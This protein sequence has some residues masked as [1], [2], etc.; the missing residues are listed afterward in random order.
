MSTQMKPLGGEEIRKA[1]LSFFEERG[2]RI[3]RS[4][5]LV[6]A[7]DPTLLFTNAGMVPFKDVFT[8]REK[9]DYVRAATVQKCVRAGGKHNDLENVGFTARHHTFFEMLGNFSFG[10]YFKEE[11]IAFAWEFLTGVL[12]MPKERLAVTVFAGEDGI[13]A[14]EEAEAIWRRVSGLPPE[15][16]QRMGAADNFWMM[17]DVGPCGPSSE[18][19]WHQGED[20]PCEEEA[21]GRKCLGI[22]CEC[23]R[24]L[25]IWNLVFM[26]FDRD[27]SGKLTPLPRPSIDTGAGLE[28]IAAVLQGKPSNYETDIFRAIIDPIGE[29]AG[30]PYESSSEELRTSMRVIADHARATS[31]LVADGVLPS[32]EGRGYVLRR[33]MRRAIRHGTRLGF[34]EPFLH[35]ICKLVVGQM[36]AAYPELAENETLILEVAR[37]EEEGFRRTLSR[38]LSLIQTEIDSRRGGEPILPGDVVFRL[39]DTYGFPVDLTR[40]IAK[41]Q[42]FLIDEDG[43]RAHLEEQRKRSVF[44]GSGEAAV[45]DL[46]LELANT[47]GK[48][49]F[50]GYEGEGVEGEGKVV[51]LIRDGALVEEA[52][53]GEAVEVVLDRT[54]FY[55]E[56]GG[57]VGDAGILTGSRSGTRSTRA[58]LEVQIRDTQLPVPGLIVHRGRVVSGILR[59]GERVEAKV[60]AERRQ[61]IRLNHSAT[62]L[63]HRAL[64]EELGSHV[65]QAGSV[66]A[67]DYLR[68]DY[69]HFQGLDPETLQKIETRVNR[70]IRDDAD[71]VTREMSLDE[72]KASG[73]Q[74]LFGE[75]YEERVRVVQV[76]PR[77]LE[78]CGGT[79]VRRSGEIGLFK[80]VSEGSIAA[81]VRRIVAVTG[82]EAIRWLHQREKETLEVARLLR[83]SPGELGSKVEAMLRRV[84]ELEKEVES[85]QG[86]IAQA[87]TGDLVAHAREVGGV[88]V[89]ST[90]APEEVADLREFADRMRNKLGSGV[91]ALGAEKNGKALL[92]VALTKD[93]VKEGLKAGDFVREMAKE[94]GGRGGGKPDLAQAGGPDPAGLDRAL[95]KIYDLVAEG[96]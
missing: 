12:G 89:L 58:E 27:A 30:K 7:N 85:L 39:Y 18:I 64:Q 13:P 53:A 47:V 90:R 16:I 24:W 40:V 10:D 22:S 5:S 36:S 66:V 61:A 94:I 54:P 21:A 50:L 52:P 3:V 35:E 65:R 69:T 46:Y 81:G 48:S 83:S 82:E 25:E 72:A 34:E 8:G 86:K 75:K 19:H 41:E 62:H 68:F 11:A 73:A 96:R 42:G 4:A 74:A 28:R 1:F 60:D 20:L 51:A 29:L 44:A 84:R 78:L 63:L 9:R 15:R 38:G 32:N 56:S 55:G 87:H 26:Q 71:T 14:D 67:P 37:S 76:H 17:G 77:S 43:F 45:G 91:V 93:L 70:M 23:D 88:K 59:V 49:T 2:H 6:P 57:Q 95:E 33:I 92:L 79:H 31:F 80:I